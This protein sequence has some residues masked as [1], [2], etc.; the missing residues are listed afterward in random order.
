MPTSMTLVVYTL[1]FSAATALD[2]GFRVPP[3]GWSSWYGFTSNIDE[4]ML[5]QM[6]DGMVS[7]G[8]HDVGY[9]NIWIDD[10]WAV[11]RDNTSNP[12]GHVIVD[13]NLFPS[14]MR[15]LSDYLHAKGLKFGIYTSKGPLTCLGTYMYMRR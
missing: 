12:P 7:S 13:S 9:D 5:R 8:L 3:M 2:N 1:L 10:G 4:L 15:N 6:A 11:G 14:G